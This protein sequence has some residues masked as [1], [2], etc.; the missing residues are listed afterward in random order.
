MSASI[1]SLPLQDVIVQLLKS[2]GLRALVAGT[3]NKQETQIEVYNEERQTY[4]SIGTVYDGNMAYLDKKFNSKAYNIIL[5]MSDKSIYDVLIDAYSKN[6]IFKEKYD[7]LLNQSR[8][9]R[10]SL[11]DPVFY[12]NKRSKKLYAI[13]R[14]DVLSMN[15]FST[16]HYV[17]SLLVKVDDAVNYT[18]KKFYDSVFQKILEKPLNQYTED[19]LTV[20]HMA[21]I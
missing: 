4:I 5:N 9:L 16:I 20:F 12:Y 15:S 10:Y 7:H 3:S 1:K 21:N 2:N 19:E 17:P 18:Y 14:I 11:C 8:P 6:I 13:P